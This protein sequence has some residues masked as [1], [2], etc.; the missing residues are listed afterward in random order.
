MFQRPKVRLPHGRFRRA[1]DAARTV[2]S[3]AG[4]GG[5]RRPVASTR[6]TR[7]RG[8]APGRRSRPGCSRRSAGVR[9]GFS[10]RLLFHTAEVHVGASTCGQDRCREVGLACRSLASS[11]SG[12][13]ASFPA[14]NWATPR[15]VYGPFHPRDVPSGRAGRPN[16]TMRTHPCA[17]PFGTVCGDSSAV[18]TPQR[19]VASLPTLGAGRTAGG[20]ALSAFQGVPV[21]LW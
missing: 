6:G 2:H 8:R 15:S 18:A 5:L 20:Q 13:N 3:G 7:C 17:P 11:G 12:R 21:R 16:N 9:P 10:G 14:N 19:G 1:P 4:R